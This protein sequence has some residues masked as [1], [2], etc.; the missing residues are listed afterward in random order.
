M[1]RISHEVEISEYVEGTEEVTELY[2]LTCKVVTASLLKIM[3]PYKKSLLNKNNKRLKKYESQAMP[4]FVE[5]KVNH[6]F[7]MLNNPV[8]LYTPDIFEEM[9]M[10]MV[11][12]DEIQFKYAQSE[13]KSHIEESIG[14]D[15]FRRWKELLRA[16]CCECFSDCDDESSQRKKPFWETRYRKIYN[17]CLDPRLS[18]K[19]EYT[20]NCGVLYWDYDFSIFYERDFWDAVQFTAITGPARGYNM[21][22]INNMLHTGGYS[23]LSDEVLS[24][25]SEKQASYFRALTYGFQENIMRDVYTM[26]DAFSDQP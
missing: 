1:F 24:E 12:D 5:N 16:F 14:K 13:L 18:Y 25:L 9:L 26:R 3:A 11:L 6:L 4:G 21:E 23:K 20:E 15:S 7:D 17:M 22:Y 10:D 8:E 19:D 2:L